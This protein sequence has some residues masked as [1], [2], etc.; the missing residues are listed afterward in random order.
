MTGP[1]PKPIGKAVPMSTWCIRFW[2]IQI[3]ELGSPSDHQKLAKCEY[4][5]FLQTAKPVFS[6]CGFSLYNFSVTFSLSFV[7][8]DG[9]RMVLEEFVL[10]KY[11]LL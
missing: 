7:I 4:G 11:L 10:I 8:S 2:Y 5:K 6:I 1:I 9:L 3:V